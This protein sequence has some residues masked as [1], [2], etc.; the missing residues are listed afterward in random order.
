MS[1]QELKEVIK[2]DKKD[3]VK[4]SI[5]CRIVFS[6]CFVISAG[7]IVAG[8]IVPPAGIIDGSVL[9]AVGLL[10][11]FPAM[12]YGF[13]AV[14]LGLEVKFQKGDTSLEIHKDDDENKED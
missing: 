3:A 4:Q 6:V 12:S 2:G 14:E 7:M 10:A 5:F 13:R 11:L 1:Y 9:T 8:F